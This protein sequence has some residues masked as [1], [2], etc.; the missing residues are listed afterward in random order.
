VLA[1]LVAASPFD[2]PLAPAVT[3]TLRNNC[4]TLSATPTTSA[5]EAGSTGAT[6][7]IVTIRS[8]ISIP[9]LSSVLI[10]SAPEAG[11]TTISDGS[12]DYIIIVITKTYGKYLSLSFALDAGGPSP[13]DNPSATILPDN[14]FTQ[15]TFPTGWAGRIYVGPNLN[16]DGSKVEGSYTGPPDI[17][18]SY[19]DSYS[20]PIRCSSRGTV[21]SGCNIDLLKQPSIPCNNPVNGPVVPKP[22]TVA[23]T[24]AYSGKREI[25]KL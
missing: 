23:K 7:I 25:A 22:E 14:T 11:S 12:G 9:A 21:V 24:V 15:Y 5:L 10:T 19:I 4:S 20:V 8:T 6:T 17:D 13:V 3:V 2:C 18:V 16:L 1:A